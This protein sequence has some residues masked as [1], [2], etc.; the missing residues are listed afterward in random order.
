MADTI[1]TNTPNAQDSGDSVLWGGLRWQ[2]S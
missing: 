2:L 1:I